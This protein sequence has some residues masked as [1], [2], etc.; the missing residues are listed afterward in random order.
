MD[1]FYGKYVVHP[2]NPSP[3]VMKKPLK[4]YLIL[5]T[6]VL[7][8]CILLLMYFVLSPETLGFSRTSITVLLCLFGLSLK[9]MLDYSID[10]VSL[11]R[12][13]NEYLDEN[14]RLIAVDDLR[15]Y[16]I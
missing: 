10:F 1:L 13:V 7:T 6:F 2:T 14:G 4:Y 8:G 3:F 12:L 15:V 9:L 5:W 11:P 16:S